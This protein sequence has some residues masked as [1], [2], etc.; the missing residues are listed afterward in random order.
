MF[1]KYLEERVTDTIA[2]KM[3]RDRER[4]VDLPNLEVALIKM[5]EEITNRKEVNFTHQDEKVIEK[6]YNMALTEHDIEGPEP[7][8]PEEA[9]PLRR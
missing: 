2:P 4:M 5:Y 6:Y 8:E 9:I 7:E 3:S 1:L